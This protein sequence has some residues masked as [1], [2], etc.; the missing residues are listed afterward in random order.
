MEGSLS[1]PLLV[2]VA[3]LGGLLLEGRVLLRWRSD[4]YFQ[5]ALPLGASL[6]P[7]PHAPEGQGR[8]PSVRWEV[9]RPGLIR[10]W[11][12]PD[13]RSAPSGLH[14]V[15]RLV[16]TPRGVALEVWWAPPWAPVLAA[17]WLM[18]LGIARGEA[19]LTVPIGLMIL[20]G[21]LIVYGDRARRVAKELRFSFVGERTLP[22]E[23]L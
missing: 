6:V 3:F 10:F 1:L 4:L 21:I 22:P 2:A 19:R 11:A 15:V 5:V 8:T 16:P 17:V 23:G 20:G 7:I 18:C 13:E 9:S 14:G 12:D